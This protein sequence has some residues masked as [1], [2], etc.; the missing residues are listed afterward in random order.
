[1][2]TLGR[3]VTRGRMLCLVSLCLAAGCTS[4][5]EITGLQGPNPLPSS[6][7]PPADLVTL[8]DAGQ[9]LTFWPYTSQGLS[10][11]PSDPINIVFVGHASPVAIRAALMALDGD[12]SSL[13]LP[14]VPPFNARWTDALGDAQGSYA[15]PGG[16]TGS[17]IQLAL[18][19]YQPIRVHLRLFSTQAPFGEGTWTLGGAHFEVLI[20][21]TTEHQVLSWEVAQQIV[22]GDLMRSGLVSG[23]SLTPMIN[24]APSFRGIPAPIYNGLPPELLALIGGPAQPVS[25]DVPLASDGRAA[26]V[27]LSGDAPL[28]AGDTVFDATLIWGQLV[29]RPFCSSG[30]LDWVYV[31]GPVHL[32]RT[33]TQDASGT[34]SFVSNYEGRV[35]VTPMNVTVNPPV[36][37]GAPFDAV[38]TGNQ[39][40]QILGTDFVLSAHDRRI[41]NEPNGI[42]M[43]RS[44]LRVGSRGEDFYDVKVRCLAP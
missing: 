24:A 35:R 31:E 33:S 42:G 25:Q 7:T 19:D 38:V 28:V 16:W 8:D 14:P 20:P 21:G 30:P 1:M 5:D 15:A 27:E 12:R 2:K 3:L 11:V 6:V 37:N 39:S 13:G 9:S 10:T 29:P 36:P 44:R 43:L 17:V 40:G 22:V 32:T 41:A 26:L 34:Y 23:V 4:K 18:G